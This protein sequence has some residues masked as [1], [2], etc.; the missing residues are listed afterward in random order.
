MSWLQETF[1]L[2]RAAAFLHR[3]TD[4]LHA[5]VWIEARQINGRK[6]NLSARAYRQLDEAWNRAY[7]PA[8]ARSEA[9]HLRKKWQTEGYKR[10]RRNGT[11]IALPVRAEQSWHPAQFTERERTRLTKALVYE[12]DEK[13]AGSHQRRASGGDWQP[14]SG[15]RGTEAGQSAAQRAVS[16]ADA[17]YQEASALYQAAQSLDRELREPAERQITESLEAERER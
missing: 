13:G 11:D 3:N 7:A 5:H 14:A 10:L 2:A 1:P 6:I 4:H 15:E 9:E 17:L 16:E 8:F 12:R